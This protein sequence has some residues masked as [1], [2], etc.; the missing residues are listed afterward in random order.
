[1]LRTKEPKNHE[2]KIPKKSRKYF[3]ELAR[4]Q[5]EYYARTVNAQTNYLPPDNVLPSKKKQKSGL[6]VDYRTSPTNIGLYMLST[7]TAQKL[8]FIKE[9]KA[10][11]RLRKTVETI[12]ALPKFTSTVRDSHGETHQVEHLYNWYKINGKLEEIGDGFIST[13]DNGNLAAFLMSTISAVGNA[14][15]ALTRDLKHIVETMRFDVL[16]NKR[17]NALY[18]G[19]QVK[20]GILYPTD[21][22]YDMLISEV[23]LTYA[24][25]I[26]QGQ[27]PAKSWK[28]LKRKLGKELDNI[29]SNPD[30]DLQSYTGTMF[31]Y[32][33]PRLL[34][35][36]D[37][38][39]LGIA[40]RQAVALQ[41][42]EKL[43]DLWGMSEA[44]VLTLLG[45]KAYGV[46]SLSQS[47]EYIADT[48]GHRI[49]AAYASQMAVGLAPAAVEANLR[50]MDK[51]GLRGK[52]GQVESVMGKESDSGID[53]QKTDQ[54][55]AHHIGMGFLAIANHLEGDFAVEW[56]HNSIYNKTRTVE[57]LLATPVTD[58]RNPSKRRNRHVEG[59]PDAYAYEPAVTYD[60][61]RVI[62][63]GEFV[64]HVPG[65]GGSTWIGQNFALSH[66][67][68]I[69]IR[70]NISGKIIPL[71]LDS[72]NSM[73]EKDGTHFLNYA[74]PDSVAGSS[75]GRLEV[76][77][78]IKMSS[79]SKTKLTRVII[80][81]KSGQTRDLQVTGYL[82]WILH[83]A[84]GY[85]DHP[86]HKNLFTLTSL[87]PDGRTV[88]AQRR[89]MLNEQDRQP[90]AFFGFGPKAQGTTA[91][92]DGSR[93]SVLG[94]LGGLEEPQAVL[95]GKSA[96]KFE[97]TLDPAAALAKDLSIAPGKSSE[98]SFV[99]GYTD[100]LSLIPK[101]IAETASQKASQHGVPHLPPDATFARMKELALRTERGPRVN[102]NPR[103]TGTT[104]TPPESIGHFANGGRKFVVDDPFAPKKPWSMVVSNG[105]YG[106]VA[107]V[108]GWVYSFGANSQQTRV[109]PYAPDITSEAPLRGVLV[110]DKKTGETF[111][112]SPNPATSKNGQYKVEV[113]PGYIKYMFRRKDGLDMTMTMFVAEKD[114][115]EF[116]QIS[117]NNKSN[118]PVDLEIS[119]FIKFAMGANYPGTAKLTKVAYDAGRASLL[120]NSPD[121][122]APDSLAFHRTVGGHS[123]TR[124]NSLK[125]TKDDPFSGLT[126]G[127]KIGVNETQEMSF[128]LGL[129]ENAEAATKYLAEYNDNA[130]VERE[131]KTQINQISS[132]LDGLQV[133]TPDKSLDVMLNTW[134]PYQSYYAHFLARSGFY[135]SGG[136]YGFR[137]QLQTVMNMI[138]SGH[139]HFRDIARKHIIEST[140]HQFEKGDVQHWWH[141][142]NNLGQRSTI[143]D[144]LLWLPLA[145]ALYRND[146][147]CWNLKEQ[148]SFAVASREL[149]PGEL[150]FV[151]KMG[152]SDNTVSVYEH[153]KKAISLVLKERMGKHGLPLMGKGDWNDGLDRVGHL[154]KGESVWLGFF[155]YDVLNKY[156]ALAKSQND[157]K[158]EKW[159]MTEAVQLKQ[160]LNKHGWNGEHFVRAYA[161]SGEV[162]SFND[163]IVAAWA[164]MSNGATP[165]KAKKAAAA[166]VK[167]LYMPEDRMI[168]L[169]K[170]LLDKES[171]GGALRAYPAGLREN[172]A[173][174][175]HGTSWLPRAM[176]QLGKGDLG[177]ELLMSMLP[178]THA[179][180]PRY[181]A[182]PFAVAADIYGAGRAGEGGWTWYSGAAGWIYRT[183]IDTTHMTINPTIPKKWPGFGITYKFE[184]TVYQIQVLNPDRISRGVRRISVDGVEVDARAGVPLIDDGKVHQV[185]VIMGKK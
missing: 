127:L 184:G 11:Q 136:A 26:M 54:F 104:E 51:L 97:A 119:S 49:I 95:A 73:S 135:Q 30:L 102:T 113:S 108:S 96:G 141:P 15:P 155:L 60:K 181:G 168:L 35:R 74:I 6:T 166:A 145:L 159:Y 63:N 152:F 123:E 151:E 69:Y 129:G 147:R 67:E 5:W 124:R 149:N 165:K 116:W 163:A 178:T 32:L 140:R 110:K 173:Q 72:P 93:L 66:N 101:I 76:T 114:P 89:S 121:A 46:G 162:V 62:G 126:T 44:N 139:S 91:W 182:E 81:N 156:A 53:Y 138:N 174:Y 12:K 103:T 48:I 36:H 9:K 94:R 176:A 160:N 171:W 175:T 88:I 82:D 144:N 128:V 56:F 3:T 42:L 83:D 153:G 132:V 154:G 61:S 167:E 172:M 55:F 2:N 80:H 92:A 22:T 118:K 130:R 4:D 18:N 85:F 164:V 169:F 137:D 13:V 29:N 37:G 79:T 58:Y 179:S 115:V 106:F 43:G 180:D 75:A 7:V 148:T 105:I 183:A 70:D 90:H 8:G 131:R 122:S 31:E 17:K 143:S 16:Y 23:R 64:A 150:D 117:V 87:S 86:V 57:S 170:Q 38:T 25:A 39:P 14:D 65:L 185:E 134:L 133:A 33:T 21:G 1:M 112:I 47:R 78:E 161:D 24:A 98:V 84:G 41:M 52:F 111:S 27:I 99:L 146:W 28:N 120:V 157:T 19:A 59:P 34:M 177:L 77:I 50:A 109:T 100:N 142:H 68:M 125:S 107:T 158:T 40:D 45:Y 10:L 20:N 71:K